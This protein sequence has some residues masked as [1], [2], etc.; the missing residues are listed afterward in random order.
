MRIKKFMFCASV[1]MLVSAVSLTGQAADK[2]KDKAAEGN[3]T[4]ETA[5]VEAKVEAKV[6]IVLE[7]DDLSFSDSTG[8]LFAK[9]HV[10][11]VQNNQKMLT[12]FLRG[13]SKQTEFWIDGKGDF[14]QP[15]TNLTGI[16]THYNYTSHTGTM[17]NAFGMVDKQHISGKTIEML[18]NEMIIHDGTTTGCP[19]KVPDYHVSAERVEIWPGDKMIAYNA[20]FWIKNT[21]IFSMGKYQTSLRKGEEKSAFPRIG[22]NNKDGMYIHQYWEVPIGDHVAA[23]LDPGYYSKSGFKPEYGIID[24]EKTY[25]IKLVQG[26]YRDDDDNWIKKEPELKFELY[27][28]RLSKLPISYTFSALYGKWTDKNK[29]SWHQDYK[30]YFSRD[31]INLSKSLFLNLGT[32]I[33]RIH[34]SYDGS[35]RNIIKFDTVL[36]KQWSPKLT[37]TAEYHYTKNNVSLFNYDSADMAREGDLGFTYKIDN[38][39]T[40]G[41]RQSYDLN[42]NKIYDQDYTW[43]R[44]LHCWQA[45]FTYRAKRKEFKW[46]FA[47]TRW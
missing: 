34:E 33:Q 24:R 23:F 44:N 45:T 13:N 31:T 17:H 37:T 36:T 11:V 30:L 25:S 14:F 5:K 42:N 8:D 18:P 2:Q 41:F 20:K 38:M 29:T 7:A 6:P 10:S 46:D 15:G 1:F 47:V 16:E 32:G 19:A 28:Q 27:S 4:K 12:E 21:E 39:N 35:N 3:K 9:G 43:Y 22:Y 40:I 26:E